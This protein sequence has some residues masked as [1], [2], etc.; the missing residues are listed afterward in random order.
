MRFQHPDPSAKGIVKSI[1][2]AFDPEHSPDD[3]EIEKEN[4]VRHV[5]IGKGNGDNGG[6]AGDGPVGGDVEPLP[7]DHDAAELAAIEMRHGIDIARVVKAALQRNGCF[8]G[9]GGSGLFCCHGSS[10]NWITAS[11]Q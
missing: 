2:A 9:G 6:A 8:V 5:A 11:P 7:P 1:T 10:I 3:G 4:D